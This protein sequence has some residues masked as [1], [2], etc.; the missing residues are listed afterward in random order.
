VMRRNFLQ[1]KIKMKFLWAHII[2]GMGQ[3]WARICFFFFSIFFFWR[4]EKEFI[5][6]CIPST[7]LCD[8]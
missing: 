4:T 7:K 1:A 3:V 6:L 2:N 5:K 8:W